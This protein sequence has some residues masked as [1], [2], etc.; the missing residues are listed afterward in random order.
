MNVWHIVVD[1]APRTKKTSNVMAHTGANQRGRGIVLPSK[2]WMRWARQ[3]QITWEEHPL[4]R[5]LGVAPQWVPIALLQPIACPV[6]CRAI[7]YRDALRGDAV[8][9]YQGLADLL[10]KRTVITNDR[11]IVSWDGSRLLK[12]AAHP[13]VELWLEQ[14]EPAAVPLEL[15]LE[16][17]ARG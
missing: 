10:E 16:R 9:Y 13:R 11:L 1:G 5:P 8:G 15:A 2:N 7:F 17:R 14:T 12:D 6:N 3:A 4:E